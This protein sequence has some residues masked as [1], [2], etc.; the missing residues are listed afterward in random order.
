MKQL[1]E[2]ATNEMNYLLIRDMQRSGLDTCVVDWDLSHDEID[3]IINRFRAGAYSESSGPVGSEVDWFSWDDA[4]KGFGYIDI[5]ETYQGV[6]HDPVEQLV[7]SEASNAMKAARKEAAAR[8]L[9]GSEAE[10]VQESQLEACTRLSYERDY[11]IADM[12]RLQRRLD[13]IDAEIA[14]MNLIS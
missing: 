8:L 9:A 5:L 11:I 12:R 7:E 13:E 4:L 3:E 2:A 1:I 14:S 6:Q 10:T